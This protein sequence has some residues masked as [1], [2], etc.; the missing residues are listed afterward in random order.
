MPN[1]SRR[2]LHANKLRKLIVPTLHVGV[3]SESDAEFGEV[4]A[5]PQDKTISLPSERI[6]LN[7]LS[8]SSQQQRSSL[9]ALLDEFKEC[10]SNIPGLCTVVTHEIHLTDDFKPRQTRAYRVPELLK[11][12]IEKQISKLLELDF[13]EV[14]DS[15]M[16]SGIVCVTKPDKSI[17]LCCDYRYLNKYTI[18]DSTP[19]KLIS[20]CVRL[21]F[22]NGN[23]YISAAN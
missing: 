23:S 16:T 3:I 14:T 9:L 13:I 8:H 12:E 2:H 18:P 20:E 4:L 21:Y 5:V 7:S 11:A 15:T 10:F 6:D 1:G 17:R 19:M 22:K